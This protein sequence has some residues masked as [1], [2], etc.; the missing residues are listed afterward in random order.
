MF[1]YD[2]YTDN[3]IVT[4]FF[5]QNASL[6]FKCILGKDTFPHFRIIAKSNVSQIKVNFPFSFSGIFYGRLI[7]ISNTGRDF[8]IKLNSIIP[9]I[10]KCPKKSFPLKRVLF[11]DR[12]RNSVN[13]PI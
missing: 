12:M 7:F 2:R 1:T 10:H 9:F 4:I 5:T 3:F 8:S 11:L 6:K 13:P